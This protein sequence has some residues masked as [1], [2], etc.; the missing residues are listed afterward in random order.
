MALT[1]GLWLKG[2]GTWLEQEDSASSS[3][4]GRSYRYNLNRDLDL[5][6]LQ[7][8]A[9]FGKKGVWAEGDAL[10]FGLL[11]GV[12]QGVLDY[13]H[14]LRRFDI[15]GG[16]VGGYVTYLSG[17]LF[18]DTL[19]KVDFLEFENDAGAPG[20]PGS[21]DATTWG[22]RTDAGY[23]FGQFRRGPCS[24]AA[25][26]RQLAEDISHTVAKTVA[27]IGDNLVG[28]MAVLARITA[29]FNN[30]DLGI[31]IANKMVTRNIDRS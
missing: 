15:E 14:L 10:L 2:S 4:Y 19:V 30:G 18:I 6:N 22:F 31:R 12:V 29:V 8:G 7:G 16:E 25:A 20:L 27:E 11:G 24:L 5:W 17:G 1:P 3:A 9:D 21:L 26:D 23:R 28:R 13:D